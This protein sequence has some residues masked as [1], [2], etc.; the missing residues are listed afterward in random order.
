MW[1]LLLLYGAASLYVV[2]RLVRALWG[3]SARI[4]AR[5]LVAGLLV[6]VVPP[7]LYF[8]LVF[9]LPFLFWVVVPLA[10]LLL[11]PEGLRYVR[12]GR[13]RLVLGL[14]A[15]PLL[16]WLVW[17]GGGRRV[18]YDVQVNRLCAQDGGIRVYETVKLPAE[19]FDKWGNVGIPNKRFARPSDE[20]YFETEIQYYREGN[21]SLERARTVI[22]RHSDGKILGES[23]RYARGGGD[24]PG[25]WHG[26][27]F[28]CPAIAMAGMP[29]LEQSIFLKG[30]GQK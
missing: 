27:S 21:P 2:W 15:L 7:L 12:G 8:V 26:T 10:A 18:Y 14:V 17:A 13:E 20:Y 6:L 4:W 1:A 19:K 24:L 23:V 22:V 16:V 3:L 28:H 5:V 9:S 25:P 29:N 30:E 11:V